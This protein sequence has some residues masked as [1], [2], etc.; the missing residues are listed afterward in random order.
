MRQRVRRA[1][2]VRRG[3]VRGRV[4]DAERGVRRRDDERAD[5]RVWC[6]R[7]GERVQRQPVSQCLYGGERRVWGVGMARRTRFVWR[8][9]RGGQSCVG[10]QCME[11]GW[12]AIATGE[13]HTCASRSDGSV[14]CWGSNESG[15]LGVVGADAIAPQ[16]VSGLAGIVQLDATSD[17]TCAASTSGGVSCWGYNIYGQI[18]DNSAAVRQTPYT[19]PSISNAR[20]AITG[21]AHTCV[22]RRD[23]TATCVGYNGRVSWE[24]ARRLTARASWRS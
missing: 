8:V 1:R 10:N 12:R 24:R 23:G 14:R 2:G 17:H 4:R 6:V 7:C 22:W 21:A 20:A 13:S 5:D 3:C 15:Q 19:I 18:G 11:A 16:L 9:R